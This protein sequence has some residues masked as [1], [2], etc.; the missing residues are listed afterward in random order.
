MTRRGTLWLV[1]ALSLAV[2][3]SGVAVVYAKYLARSRFVDLQRLRAERDEL[4]I[5]W[6]RLRLEEATLTTHARVEALAR[7]DLDMH[8]PRR[9]DVRLIWGSHDD[10]R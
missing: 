10:Q 4:A 1:L 8:L 6:S 2:S 3:L 7:R 9:S 5:E